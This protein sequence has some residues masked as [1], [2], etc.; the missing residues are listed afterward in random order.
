MDRQ[1]VIEKV[2]KCFALARSKGATANEAETALRQGRWLMD[3]YNLEERDLH[4]CLATEA[5]VPTSTRRDPPNWLYCL[6]Q[7][8]ATAF[9]CNYLA[10][11]ASR[12]GYAFKFIGVGI[13]PE[14]AAYAYSAL[15]QQLLIARRKHVSEQTRCKLS[16]KR[17]RGQL[18]AEAW[19]SAVNDK[20][21]RFAGRQPEETVQAIEAYLAIHHPNLTY[22]DPKQIPVRGHDYRSLQE[23]WDQ[24]STAYL[25]QGV[26]RSA[27]TQL[28]G[29]GGK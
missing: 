4:A 20:V 27:Q 16:T 11:P 25:H 28:L 1:R 5:I 3:Q 7:T 12:A 2:A 26:S 10:F 13:S 15:H 14:L 9:G 24:G 6:A 22:T 18:F 23:G 21:E 8:C 19:I 29:G 17:R